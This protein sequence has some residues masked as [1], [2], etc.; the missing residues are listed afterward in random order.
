[1]QGALKYEIYHDQNRVRHFSD[2][3]DV[4]VL[5]T[6]YG[7]VTAEYRKFRKVLFYLKWFRIVLDEGNNDSEIMSFSS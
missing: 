6:T 3:A 1:V 7:T 4:D 5:I 2:L